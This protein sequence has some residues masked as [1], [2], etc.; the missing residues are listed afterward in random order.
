MNNIM[1]LGAKRCGKSTIIDALR[2]LLS[3]K[4]YSVVPLNK[5]DSIEEVI[6]QSQC[7]YDCIL[8]EG[9]ELA[10]VKIADMADASVVLVG[11]IERGGVFAVLYGTYALLKGQRISGFLVNKFRGDGKLLEPGLLFLEEKTGVPF[12]GVVPYV[13]ARDEFIEIFRMSVELDV[14]SKILGADL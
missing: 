8:L 10:D 1:F 6:A 3:E 11:D 4:G 7:E 12:V 2:T 13:S 14:I 5:H 9:A